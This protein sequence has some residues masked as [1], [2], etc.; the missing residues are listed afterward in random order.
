MVRAP[1][2]WK[3]RTK[4]GQ[5]AGLV[6][7]KIHHTFRHSGDT[8]HEHIALLLQA[9]GIGHV[10]DDGVK[11]REHLTKPQVLT[12]THHCSVELE[13]LYVRGRQIRIHALS[14][15]TLIGRLIGIV[16]HC[17]PASRR[18]DEVLHPAAGVLT[19]CFLVHIVVLGST[20]KHFFFRGGGFICDLPALQQSID[21]VRIVSL[22]KDDGP[23]HVIQQPLP[24]LV[25][26]TLELFAHLNREQ[27]KD[28]IPE[29]HDSRDRDI[30]V[31]VAETQRFH[32]DL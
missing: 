6:L 2:L 27:V 8:Q 11:A 18:R 23:T 22:H 32:K 19:K 1:V 15:D 4:R 21:A 16:V 10:R 20:A 3:P 17:F 29:N 13:H 31:Q 5:H 12:E 26:G 7:S 25:C 24:S 9:G 30:E 28:G 14:L